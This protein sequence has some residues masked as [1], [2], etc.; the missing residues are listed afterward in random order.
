MLRRSFFLGS[1]SGRNIRK[2]TGALVFTLKF[3]AYELNEAFIDSFSAKKSF[4]HLSLMPKAFF[5]VFFCVL[6]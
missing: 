4:R 1:A 5:I 6:H 3:F 2:Q